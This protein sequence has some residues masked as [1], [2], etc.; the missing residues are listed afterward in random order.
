MPVPRTP[1]QRS[2][3]G[4]RWPAACLTLLLLAGCAG[5]PGRNP[6]AKWM[7]SPNYDARTPTLIVVHYTQ[8]AD[9][10]D[11][12]HTL[13]TRNAK[14]PVSAH[15]LIGK[16]GTVYQ[17][18]ADGKRAWQ[19]GGSFWS[20]AGDVNSRSIGIELDNNGDEAF[21]PQQIDALLQLLGDLTGR[22]NIRRTSIVGHADVAET[23]RADPGVFFPWS[24]L[25][26]HGFGLWYDPGPLP[27]PPPG[28][29]PMVALRLIGYSVTDPVA[30]IVA[31]HRHFR[32]NDKPGLDAL[33]QRILWNLQGKLMREGVTPP[34]A[35][36]TYQQLK[37]LQ[38]GAR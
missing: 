9:V 26:A 5:V 34:P 21:P 30:A 18:V 7:P 8:E 27:E 17:L 37:A 3:C 2:T 20:G 25:A 16:S 14:G 10:Q 32:A 24:E 23:R 31:Y 28:F 13:R 36:E 33:D 11:A 22:Y 6:L 35:Q 12:L 29:D 19:A 38:P 1:Q 4:P 15:Y